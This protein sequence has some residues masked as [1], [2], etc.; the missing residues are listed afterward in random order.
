MTKGKGRMRCWRLAVIVLLQEGWHDADP[1]PGFEV[2]TWLLANRRFQ[3]YSSRD[4][5]IL[6]KGALR[7]ALKAFLSQQA[8]IDTLPHA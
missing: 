1:N 3:A 4:S 8:R 2:V 6:D 7:K 5:G